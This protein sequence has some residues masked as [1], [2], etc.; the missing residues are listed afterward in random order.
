MAEKRTKA[1]K[2]RLNVEQSER[3]EEARSEIIDISE[4]RQ[5][6]AALMEEQIRQ[7]A[8]ELYQARGRKPGHEVEDWLKAEAEVRAARHRTPAASGRVIPFLFS[9]T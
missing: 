3:R 1:E 6:L 7:R 5:E 2:W 4:K 9:S 8:H